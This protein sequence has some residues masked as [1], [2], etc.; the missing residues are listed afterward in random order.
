MLHV[1]HLLDPT[2]GDGRAASLLRIEHV[3]VPRSAGLDAVA[4]LC[5]RLRAVPEVRRVDFDAATYELTVTAQVA[6]SVLETLV[7]ELRALG[8]GPAPEVA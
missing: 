6:Y 7:R 3:E 1:E 4:A 8:A 2:P 5:A